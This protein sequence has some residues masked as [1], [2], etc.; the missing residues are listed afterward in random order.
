MLLLIHIDGSASS[1]VRYLNVADLIPKPVS[2][3][4]DVPVSVI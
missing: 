1:A 3:V 4:D 2:T